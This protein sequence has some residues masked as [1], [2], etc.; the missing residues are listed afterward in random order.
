MREEPT[1]FFSDGL[2]L[3]ASFF[4]PAGDDPPP[5]TPVIVPCSGFMGLKTIHPER[6]ARALTPLGYPCFTFDYRGF[7]KMKIV[8]GKVV[9]DE[10]VRDIVHA[11]SFAAGDPRLRDRRMVL[12][13][14]GMG[15]GLILEATP[16]A[17]NVQG[18]ICVNGLYDAIRVQRAVR[19]EA[20][21]RT[22]RAWLQEQ[23]LKACRTDET[24]QVDPFLV[25][26]L[27]PVTKEYVDGPL[28]ASPGFG[29]TVH[30]AFAESLLRFA[31][32]HHLNHLADVP[33]LVVHGEDNRLHPLLEGESLYAAY[34]GPKER[35]WIPGAGHTEWM[36]DDHPT[37]RLVAD[38]VAAWL[39]NQVS[40]AGV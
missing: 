38:R 19:G 24:T 36:Y 12:L 25:Y 20:G 26:P 40:P 17:P 35:F 22:F 6:F 9:I 5:E 16:I 32:E 28:N 21:W 23:Q 14:W 13:G 10:Q 15:A 27:D 4:F 3:D 33:L 2:R 39:A 30:L 8:G 37:F 1:H 7:G 34:P 11:I 18:L 31:P 29:G